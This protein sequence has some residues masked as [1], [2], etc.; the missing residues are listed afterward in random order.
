MATDFKSAAHLM[1]VKP[2]VEVQNSN[3]CVV[4]W[5]HATLYVPPVNEAGVTQPATRIRVVPV[6]MLGTAL[7]ES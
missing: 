5:K 4:V 7:S 3:F 2:T 6:P 1:F